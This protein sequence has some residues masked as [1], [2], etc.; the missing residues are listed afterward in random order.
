MAER[1]KIFSEIVDE[2]L[3]YGPLEPMLKDPSVSDILVNSYKSIYVERMGK[4]EPTNAR[5]KTTRI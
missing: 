2:V 1:E 3:G 5:F 4:L